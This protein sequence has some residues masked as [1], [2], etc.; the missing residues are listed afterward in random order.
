MDRV[1]TK[2]FDTLTRLGERIEKCLPIDNNDY[3]YS[4]GLKRSGLDTLFSNS[5]PWSRRSFDKN[6]Y[7]SS[8]RRDLVYGGTRNYFSNKL[9][10]STSDYKRY[11]N[12]KQRQMINSYGDSIVRSPY[13][14]RMGYPGNYGYQGG[15]F[16]SSP[17]AP[18]GA[19]MGSVGYAPDY[20]IAERRQLEL[21]PAPPPRYI[22]QPVPVAVPVDRPVPQPYP[23]EV[24]KPVP[25]DRPVPVSVDRPVPVPVDRPVPVPVDRPVAVPVPTPV[26]VDRP[27][28]VSVDRPVPVPVDRPVAVP[29]PSP[30]PVDRPVPICVPVPVPS[31]SSSPIQV[32]VASPPPS[33]VQISVPS[34]V[35]CYV[36]VSVPVLS[37]PAS[38]VMVENSVTYAQRWVNNSPV[39]LNQQRHMAGSPVMGM[40]PCISYGNNSSFIH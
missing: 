18:Y 12:H 32:P 25:V 20:Y 15:Y 19:A 37:A 35:T 29:V 13:G 1:V 4:T 8:Q 28:P 17:V 11:S 16:G 22:Q 21:V 10:A 23:V 38:P 14:P 7:Y 30:V 27:V 36:P 39:I 5:G 9:D 3:N 40:N 34:Q 33:P 31:P 6:N 2:T 26:A 24:S